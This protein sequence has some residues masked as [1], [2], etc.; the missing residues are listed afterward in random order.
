MKTVATLL[1]G[2][3]FALVCA[4]SW[5]LFPLLLVAGALM[6]FAYAMVVELGVSLSGAKTAAPTGS[7]A[8]KL[9]NRLCD[10]H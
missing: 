5:V 2:T 9:A 3:V 6:L 7:A 1:D 10:T 4:G 8:R